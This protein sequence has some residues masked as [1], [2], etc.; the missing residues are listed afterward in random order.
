MLSSILLVGLTGTN[1]PSHFVQKIESVITVLLV[2][3]TQY[4]MGL[5]LSIDVVADIFFWKKLFVL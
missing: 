1:L 5:G 4:H 2:L 3:V